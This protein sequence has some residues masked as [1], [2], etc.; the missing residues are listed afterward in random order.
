MKK[1]IVK[2]EDVLDEVALSI[3]ERDVELIS[4]ALTSPRRLQILKDVGAASGPYAC[5]AI[6]Q[7]LQ[8]SAATLS[9]HI[10]ELER[11]GLVEVIRDG[12]FMLLTLKREVLRAYAGYLSG[13]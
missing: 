10:K 13:F 5:T 3:S 8:I 2:N 7:S 6:S 4:S 1:S 11:A 9:Y 12:K